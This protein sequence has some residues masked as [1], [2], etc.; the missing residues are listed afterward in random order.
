MVMMLWGFT[1]KQLL[2]SGIDVAA[3]TAQVNPNRNPNPNPNPN[4]VSGILSPTAIASLS[5]SGGRTDTHADAL[6][7]AF[8]TLSAGRRFAVVPLADGG[9]FWFATC[10]ALYPEGRASR[11]AVSAARDSM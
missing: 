7:H 3:L 2:L 8:E 1:T 4:Q 6:A 5:D 9:A 10:P 11:G